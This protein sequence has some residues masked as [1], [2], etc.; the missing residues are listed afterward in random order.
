MRSISANVLRTF[1]HT[2]K[3]FTIELRVPIPKNYS[4]L[5]LNT[6]TYGFVSHGTV[7][8]RYNEPLYNEVL[9]ITND[10]FYPS[11]NKI[12]GN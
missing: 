4:N 7:E 10:F 8:P 2:T 5:I 11:N 6:N 3:S 9:G 1:Y 12:Y